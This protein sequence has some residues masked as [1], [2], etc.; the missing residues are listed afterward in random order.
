MVAYVLVLT[1]VSKALVEPFT[2]LNRQ[3]P[4]HFGGQ[5]VGLDNMTSRAM[6]PVALLLLFCCYGVAGRLHKEFV[7][8][9]GL[10]KSQATRAFSNENEFVQKAHEFQAMVHSEA[11]AISQ[12]VSHPRIVR[13]GDTCDESCWNLL[14]QR[15]GKWAVSRLTDSHLTVVASSAD[16]EAFAAEHPELVKYHMAMLPEM[17]V[18]ADVSKMAGGKRDACFPTSTHMHNRRTAG[19]KAVEVKK[20]PQTVTLRVVMVPLQ[21]SDFDS[22]HAHVVNLEKEW[23]LKWDYSRYIPD[24]KRTLE[25][26]LTSCANVARVAQALSRRPEVYWIERVYPAYTH[27]RWSNGVCDS[28]KAEV[29]PLQTNPNANFTGLGDI[30]GVSDTGIDMQNC[31]FRD[32]EVETP[33]VWSDEASA[34][35]VNL[36]HR[37]VHPLLPFPVSSLAYSLCVPY[38]RV[39][40]ITAVSNVPSYDRCR[41]CSTTCCGRTTDS[42]RTASTTTR[43]TAHTSREVSSYLGAFVYHTGLARCWARS[44]WGSGAPVFSFGALL[45]VGCGGRCAAAACCSVLEL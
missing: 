29:S 33:Y 22:F 38:W 42:S 18:D 12:S 28:G 34:A 7:E 36:S 40:S 11:K 14:Q 17:K 44:C 1:E 21:P 27:N 15:F 30:I 2:E 4:R 31:Y 43:D 20:T 13:A 24:R 37:K 26:T 9:A 16:V 6:R 5:K 3:P 10:L 25:V 45:R 41:W 19:N 32:E 8:V 39:L 23:G 35:T